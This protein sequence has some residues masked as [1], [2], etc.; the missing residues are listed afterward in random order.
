MG[1]FV[2]FTAVALSLPVFA[3][4]SSLDFRSSAKTLSH[5]HTG[6]V[7]SN[8]IFEPNIAADKSNK[9]RDIDVAGTGKSETRAEVIFTSA[10]T[11][12]GHYGPSRV[13]GS[14]GHHHDR[15]YDD[16]HD[17]DRHHYRRH[18]SPDP[19][20]SVVPEPPTLGLL[21]IGL[22][23]VAGLLRLRARIIRV[24]RTAP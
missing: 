9:G 20:A 11:D 1:R 5:Q 6:Y 8:K 22:L 21:G 19:R 13:F 18:E 17:S 4:A 2:F 24:V 16:D 12:Y 15:R 3:Y 14:Y 23:G 7:V 10:I